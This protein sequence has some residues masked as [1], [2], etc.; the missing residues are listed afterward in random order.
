[1]AMTSTSRLALGALALVFASVTLDRHL[2]SSTDHGHDV[3]LLLE[4]L[5]ELRTKHEDLHERVLSVTDVDASRRP[6][7]KRRRQ[8]TTS[9][10]TGG[11]TYAASF[12]VVG[13]SLTDDHAALTAA[14]TSAA[15][16]THGISGDDEGGGGGVVVLPAG[17]FRINEPLIIPA[18]VTLQGQGYGSS[19]LAIQVRE[20]ETVTR[21]F[22]Q[23]Q[24]VISEFPPASTPKAFNSTILFLRSTKVRRR[25][26]RHRVLRIGPRR[27]VP[28][29]LGVPPRPGR[30]RH[31]RSGRHG[32]SRG[33]S[34]R[35]RHT[36]RRRRNHR[37]ESNGIERFPVLLP[38]R[39]G[40]EFGRE[41]QRRHRVWELPEREGPACQDRYL[42][43]GRG[44]ELRELQ[45]V[46]CWWYGKF[47][48]GPR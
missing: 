8:Q 26:V 7:R 2:R 3:G 39:A 4:Q 10:C 16:V 28:R 48:Q 35:W 20:G 31:S 40:R 41:E 23:L 44:G 42:S 45:L 17:T 27:E 6:S 32:L 34:R 25:R 36:R 33:H 5:E 37:R 38:G 1:M 30:V 43:E 24:P 15:A 11:F 19:P 18:G 9:N 13:D 22:L 47:D 14:L 12:G 21:S 46:L 29:Q